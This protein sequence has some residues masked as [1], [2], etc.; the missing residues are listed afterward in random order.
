MIV[1]KYF[2]KPFQPTKTITAEDIQEQAAMGKNRQEMASALG[3]SYKNLSR[4]IN[5]KLS[6]YEAENNGQAE[7]AATVLNERSA[8]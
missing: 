7:Y 4:K 3:I 8:K 2:P 1:R 5:S 6:F